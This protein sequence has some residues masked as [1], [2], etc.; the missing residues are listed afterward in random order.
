MS[1]AQVQVEDRR[2]IV[3][4]EVFFRDYLRSRKDLAQE[5]VN[6]LVN[7]IRIAVLSRQNINDADKSF[8]LVNLGGLAEAFRLLKALVPT[9]P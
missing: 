2:L 3:P 5:V 8:F 4:D 9:R 6:D 7:D 1:Q